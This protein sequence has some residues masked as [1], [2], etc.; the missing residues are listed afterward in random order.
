VTGRPAPPAERS[1]SISATLLHDG[2]R[3]HVGADG[4]TIGREEG[5][6]LQLA[7]PQV[8]RLH[9]R[10][11]PGAR[12]WQ[13]T[14]LRSANGTIL[15]GERLRGE[16]RP[17]E[18]GDTI[19]VGGHLLRFL[20]GQET[21]L[22]GGA[23]RALRAEAV[24]MDGPRLRIGRDPANDLVLD[25]PNV[26]RL[27]AEVVRDGERLMLRDLGS[28]NG[29]RVDGAITDRAPLVAGS[30]IGIGPYRL[31]FDGTQF[32]ARDERGA[33]RLDAERLSVRV[34]GK[35]IL[36]DTT[37]SVEPNELVVVIGES[38]SGKSTLI[39][40]LAGVSRPSG[41]T[42]TVSGEP[43][44]A[45][46]TD[47][48]YV[49]QDEI[50]HGGLTVREA[51]RYSARLR[52]PRDAT[53]GDVEESVQRVMDELSLREHAGTRIA[54]LSG[55][56]RKRAGVATELLSRPSL[57]FLDEPTTG[58]DPGLE[59]RMMHL[60][61]DLADESR[62]VV[63]VTHATKNLRL[64]DRLIV[65]GRGG[66]LCFEGTPDEAL[67]FFEVEDFDDIYVALDE[68]DTDHW[69]GR[70]AERREAT[71]PDEVATREVA[72][73]RVARRDSEPLSHGGVLARRYL[74]L[75]ARDPRNLAILIGQAPLL[76]LA[77]AG[78]FGADTFS[79]STGS[80][81]DAAQLL[82]FLVITAT[83]LGAIASSREIIR[84][85][86]V[87]ERERA[88][89]VGLGAYMVSKMAILAL[90][91]A[92]QVGL[93]VGIVLVLRPLDEPA[94]AYVTL[95]VELLL[96]GWAAVALGLVV[97]AGVRSQEQ[98]TSFI[99]LVLI[100]QLLFGGA[101]VPI[102]AMAAPLDT[103]SSAVFARWSFA[104]VGTAID[105]NGRMAAKPGPASAYGP[106]FFDLG[107]LPTAVILSLFT[108]VFLLG[109][110]ALLARR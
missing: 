96:T 22:G 37:L 95:V 20:A 105:M 94:G 59:S 1:D 8:S 63:V 77:I 58:L 12:G 104:G 101:I 52:L 107:A 40:A 7:S 57:L 18:T 91:S 60:L 48:G 11:E 97:S 23:R 10:I 110:G 84:E 39:K 83:W 68:T 31:L 21:R 15:N 64:C 43:V 4:L 99:P 89:G 47:I 14:D 71:A 78:L 3:V 61:R 74:R 41:G 86:S 35:E 79:R 75:L 16:S 34:K 44:A 102:A 19:S 93:L 66:H 27:H 109:A 5:T 29:T 49:P 88:V 92:V 76:A 87:F 6:G 80:P 38:G 42:V 50:V 13:V 36:A 25:D 108:A 98:A 32:I 2:G 81:S 62:A 55:G 26:S 53:D 56:Q 67:T 9:A 82:F 30:E 106:S 17:L 100:P 45:R 46:L 90:L 24:R 70:F 69:R 103:L 54:S 65:M 72:V 85:R 33:L 73:E 28:R 51:L